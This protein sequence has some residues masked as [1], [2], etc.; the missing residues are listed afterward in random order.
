[1][2]PV[3]PLTAELVGELRQLRC[4]YSAEGLRD[5]VRAI[6]A[7][8]VRIETNLGALGLSLPARSER[9]A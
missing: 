1:M 3:E 9:T 6:D 7:T 4:R 5:N 8:L 2:W